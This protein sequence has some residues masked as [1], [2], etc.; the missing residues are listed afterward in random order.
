MPDIELKNICK[1]VCGDVCL[2]VRDGEFLVLLGPNGSGKTTLLNVIAGLI[3]YRGS[4][5]FNGL[6]VDSVSPSHRQVSYL[7]QELMLFPHLDVF[8]NIAYGLRAHRWPTEQVSARVEELLRMLK[9]EHLVKRYPAHLSGGEKQRVALARALAISPEVLLLDEP[10]S[11][12][13]APSAKYLRIE[14]KQLQRKLGVTTVY[15]THDLQEAEEMADR[16]AIIQN[17]HLEQVGA[18]DR[19]F[20]NPVSEKVADFIG[21]P[22]ILECE[23]CRSAGHGVMEVGCGGL[24]IIVPH[25]G[26]SIRKIAILPQDI[27]VSDIKPPGPNL[28]HFWGT[29]S[30]VEIRTE[31]VRLR[32][33]AGNN[34]LLAEMPHHTFENMNL[35]DGREVLIILRI[36]RIKAYE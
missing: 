19:V 7:L 32:I 3:D 4:V 18:P 13:D 2:K 27:Y 30:D 1:Y 24:S 21:A 9:I 34:N 33:K 5:L 31:A 8:A 6:V 14:L 26:D 12:L 36:R 22:N 23:Y 15:V 35:T 10:L 17:G 16:I 28:N 11:S 20:F 29:I 25:D